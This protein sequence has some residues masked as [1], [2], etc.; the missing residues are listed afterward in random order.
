MI[1]RDG[2]ILMNQSQQYCVDSVL[3]VILD[4]TYVN[5]CNR[6]KR[7]ISFP[8]TIYCLVIEEKEIFTAGQQTSK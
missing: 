4:E 6:R 2:V 8:P 5:K 7:Q 1:L 3:V